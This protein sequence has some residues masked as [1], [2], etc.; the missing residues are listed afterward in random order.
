MPRKIAMGA[1]VAP[2]P[3]SL[4]ITRAPLSLT[5]VFQP[6]AFR[7]LVLFDEFSDSGSRYLSL[8]HC[9]FGV[10]ADGGH[11]AA[12]QMTFGIVV[13]VILTHSPGYSWLFI[14]AGLLLIPH[15]ERVAPS[16]HV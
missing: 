1:S 5:I 13:G 12:G 16:Y 14:V 11:G 4:L 3:V 2:S 15:I 10:T 9:G 8:A 6:G 7:A